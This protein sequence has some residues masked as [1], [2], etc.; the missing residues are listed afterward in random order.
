MVLSSS[1]VN[2]EQFVVKLKKGSAYKFRNRLL[3]TQILSMSKRIMNE[4]MYLAGDLGIQIYY[5]NTE[6][7]HIPKDQSETLA[8]EYL[9]KCNRDLIR[10]QLVQFHNDFPG[11]TTFML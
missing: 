1:S 6:L 3:Y 11:V 10:N 5:Q 2:S 9:L 4:V 7:T 8:H